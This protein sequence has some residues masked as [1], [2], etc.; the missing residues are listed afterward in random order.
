MP[1]FN[2]E[3]ITLHYH[4]SYLTP[5]HHNQIFFILSRHSVWSHSLTWH[6]C[7]V[8]VLQKSPS[9]MSLLLPHSNP[10]HTNFSCFFSLDPLLMATLSCLNGGY[11]Y[12]QQRQ[13][14]I[15]QFCI[16]PGK[17]RAQTLMTEGF[18]FNTSTNFR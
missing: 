15:S 1:A 18:S 10:S 2:Q 6:Q 4:F 5:F 13:E 11:C 3:I 16:I 8:R 17:H 12:R 7:H 9:L 14:S